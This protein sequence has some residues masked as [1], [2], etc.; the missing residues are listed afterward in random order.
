MTSFTHVYPELGVCDLSKALE[1]YT[2]LMGFSLD[3]RAGDDIAV[4]TSGAVALFLRSTSIGGLGPSR[5]ILNV[6][7][8]DAVFASWQANGVTIVEPIETRSWGMRE[9]VASDIDGNEFRV[10]HVD[11]SAADYGNFEP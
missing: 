5:V 6:G 3:W 4:V 10:G 7:D 9:F 2:R 1:H 8:A 11:E